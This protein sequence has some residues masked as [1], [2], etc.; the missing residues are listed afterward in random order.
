M[1]FRLDV[2]EYIGGKPYGLKFE[3]DTKFGGIVKQLEASA[4]F[5]LAF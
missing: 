5:G 3:Q 2:R 4:G 1:L